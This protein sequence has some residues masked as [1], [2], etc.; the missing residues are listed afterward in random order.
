MCFINVVFI[1]SNVS[2]IDETIYLV[3]GG[4]WW[5]LGPKPPRAGWIYRDMRHVKTFA[6]FEAREGLTPG[7]VQF[8]NRYVKGT[9]SLNPET[10]LVDVEGSFVCTGKILT[11]LS[12]FRFGTVSEDFYF[13]SNQLQ[14]L[15]GGPHTVGKDY[16]CGS[17]QLRSL[18]GAPRVVGGNFQCAGN[19]LQ[20]L[21]GGPQEVRGSFYCGLNQLYS[22]EGAPQEV[23]L[24]FTCHQNKLT[25]LE[26]A[27]QT[28]G[29]R[30]DCRS[31]NLTSLVGAPQ[32]IVGNF[33]CDAFDIPKGEWNPVGWWTAAQ[34]NDQAA[35]LLIPLLTE[36]QLDSWMTRNPLDL[37]LLNDFPEIK[38]GV[39]KRTGMRDIS[40]VASALR[41]KFI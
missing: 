25:S 9:W 34:K 14:T 36:S 1:V 6:L 31:N 21:E 28:V 27:P 17:N 20:T 32:E 10:G 13:S 15:E 12:G 11:G 37:D 24:D 35:K 2:L 23:G 39:L 22:L 16:N 8:L 40:K 18:K 29:G 38:S 3:G 26:G 7:Q 33:S 19:K 4:S 5:K 41:N 30:F